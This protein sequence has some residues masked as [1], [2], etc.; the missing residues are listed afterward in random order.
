MRTFAPFVAGVGEMNY[1]KFVVYNV[2]GALAW[3][4]IFL[5]LGYAFGDITAVKENITLLFVAIILIS[6]L[7]LILTWLM[8]RR[9][10]RVKARRRRKRGPA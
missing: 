8:D 1:R 6:F 3:V 10:K 4:S 7:P 5:G 9:K 2:V